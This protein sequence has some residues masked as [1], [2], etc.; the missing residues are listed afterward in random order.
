MDKYLIEAQEYFR[1]LST[2]DL[3]QVLINAG[4][5]VRNGAGRIIFTNQVE[6]KVGFTIKS[7]FKSVRKDSL[8]RTMK[9][10]VLSFPVAC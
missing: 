7:T 6:E 1:S 9:V 8:T 4:F 5:D 10:N 2:E 3:K